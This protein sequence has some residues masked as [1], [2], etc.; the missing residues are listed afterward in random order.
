MLAAEGLRPLNVPGSATGP[1]PLP[2]Y[3]PGLTGPTS[4]RL[5]ETMSHLP[6]QACQSAA[7]VQA[8]NA[9]LTR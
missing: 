9:G 7:A 4:R 3:C 2:V 5:R 8:A 1:L 6:E